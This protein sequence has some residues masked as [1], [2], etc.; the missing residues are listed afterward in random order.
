[1]GIL[2]DEYGHIRLPKRHNR[3]EFVIDDLSIGELIA[4]VEDGNGELGGIQN[5][6]AL[7]HTVTNK[8]FLEYKR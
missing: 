4:Q 2:G 1:M 6:V 5:C 3:P 8:M 7:D